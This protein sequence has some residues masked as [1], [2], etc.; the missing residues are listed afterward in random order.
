MTDTWKEPVR[1]TETG[2]WRV[3]RFDGQVANYFE[4]REEAEAWR[5]RTP[6][7]GCC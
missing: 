2:K 7:G 4:T 6:G 1:E 5:V 3:D